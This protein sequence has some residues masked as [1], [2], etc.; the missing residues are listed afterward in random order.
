MENISKSIFKIKTAS[1]SG[2]GFYL[3]KYN[4]FI[5]NYHVVEGHHNV[6]IEDNDMHTIAAKVVLANIDE[7]LAI[8]ITDEKINTEAELAFGSLENLKSR[9][10]VFVLGYP[11]GMPYTETQGIVS[12][13]KQLMEGKH[14]IQTD[15]PVNPGNSGGPLVNKAGEIVGITTAKFNDADNMG[16][17]V[18]VSVLQGILDIYT[19]SKPTS[20]GIVCR[21][22]KHVETTHTEN[23]ENC[24]A[25]INIAIFE[26]K[27]ISNLA[28]RVEEGLVRNGINPIIARNGY[29]YWTFYQG[30]SL[31]RIYIYDYDFVCS[32]SPM[33]EIGSGNVENVM[34]YLLSDPIAPYQLGTYESTIYIGCR[35]HVTDLFNEKY[36]DEQLDRLINLSKKADELDNY[37]L[38]TYGCPLAKTAKV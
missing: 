7:D 12:S 22:C 34:R 31:V 14:Y 30:S 18:P 28:K 33:N 19:T 8:L 38:E 36:G 9:D 23:C 2:S 32:S 24:G 13:P 15:A 4:V 17:A 3:S 5:T 1:G 11:F 37:L 29:E 10:E 21:D 20:F 26:E 25:D 27:E 6:A 16:F 35:T